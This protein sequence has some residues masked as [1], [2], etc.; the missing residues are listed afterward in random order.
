LDDLVRIA[1][2]SFRRLCIEQGRI[3][4]A[5]ATAPP[6]FL[7]ISHEPSD[8]P[9][10][11]FAQRRTTRQPFSRSVMSDH[12]PAARRRRRFFSRQYVVPVVR[13]VLPWCSEPDGAPRCRRARRGSASSGVG[14]SEGRRPVRVPPSVSAARPR[15]QRVYRLRRAIPR[16]RTLRVR[17]PEAAVWG[18]DPA[19]RRRARRRGRPP[20]RDPHL[21]TPQRP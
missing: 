17:P 21:R 14:P 20:P 2:D 13:D 4:V 16:M 18:R 8:R 12:Y 3:D 1:A 19:R 11:A 6:A 9:R 15:Q 7:R 5:E 10:Y